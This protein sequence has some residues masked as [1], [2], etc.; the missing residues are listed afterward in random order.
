MEV[1]PMQS[2]EKQVIKLVKGN[3]AIIPDVRQQEGSTLLFISDQLQETGNYEL[4]KQD[5]TLSII[6]FNDNRKESDMSYLTSDNL[7]QIFPRAGNILKPGQASIK[8]EVAESNFGLQ[9]WKLCIIL[10]L[11]FLAAE[12]LLIRLYHPGK[13]QVSEAV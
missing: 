9:L 8:N 12:I 4:K 3:Q 7:K 1:P 5:S 6:A 10:A 2:S 13:Q 11:I